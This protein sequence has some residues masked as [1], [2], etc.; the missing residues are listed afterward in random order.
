M[1]R[2]VVSELRRRI[3]GFQPAV[4]PL[5]GDYS[6]RSRLGLYQICPARGHAGGSAFKR[7]FYG[8]KVFS[9]LHSNRVT[10]K[11]IGRLMH[12]YG[13]VSLHQ[14]DALID[15]SGF[16][17]S[18]DW[19]PKPMQDFAS[20]AAYYKKRKKPVI[21]LPQ[22]FGPF[23]NG[24]TRAAILKVIKNADLIFARD[25][26]SYAY[27]TEIKSSKKILLAP[28]IT[29][30]YPHIEKEPVEKSNY[31]CVI[32]NFRI[33]THSKNVWGEKYQQYLRGA[34]KKILQQ[35]CKVR[36]VIHDT[37]GRDLNLAELII[38]S[39]DSSALSILIEK[40]AL[41][42]KD[43]I[44]HSRFVIGSRYHSLVA[45]FSYAVPSIG[46]GWS[47]KYEALFNSFNCSDLFISPEEPMDT[48]LSRIEFLLDESKNLSF[49][50]KI[51]V[52]LEAMRITNEKMWKRAV[53][54]LR[55]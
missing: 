24:M 1:L 27:L 38:K 3:K 17:F 31:V 19:G 35:G 36:V 53:R 6:Q 23:E 33:I 44:G 20:L 5:C 52:K 13:C 47:H 8:Q 43:E 7:R 25:E 54:I 2:A 45:A 22:A 10:H 55:Q 30:F 26:L 37:S 51:E 39:I 12:A 21:M 42:L 50:R 18:D 16:A 28:D 15:I 4:D 11:V 14:I 32:P 46:L 29:L 34:V 40:D 41:K 48:L 9:K 49:Q